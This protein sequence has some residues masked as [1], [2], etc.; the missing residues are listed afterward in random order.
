MPLARSRFLFGAQCRVVHHLQQLRERG[1]VGQ[2]FEL[3]A[4]GRRARVGAVLHQVAPPELHRIETGRLRGQVNQ[5]FRDRAGDGMAHGAVLA[6]RRLVLEHHRR[7]GAV[8]GKIVR[9]AHQVH[10]LIAF[11]RAGARVDRVGADAR[12]VIDID[13]GDA[14]LGIDRHAPLDAMIAGMDV[15]CEAFQPVGNELDR[16]AHDLGDDRHRY[17]I[18]ID[19]HLDAVAAA[20]VGADHAHVALGQA[21]VLGEHALHH[22]RR[23]GSVIDGKLARAAIVV[24]EDRPRLQRCARVARRVER[25]LDHLVGGSE[26]LLH[27]A[28][29]V[30][31]LKTKIVTQVR[32]DD[33]CVRCQGSLHLDRR[34]QCLVADIDLGQRVLGG[35]ARLGNYSGDRLAGPGGALQRQRQLRG[36]FHALEMRQHRD[37]GVAMLGEVL[38]GEH[39]QHARHCER[40]RGV[41]ID[42]PGV[43]VRAPDE[44]HVRHARQHDVVDELSAS[45]NQ[46]LRVGSRYR[47]ADIGIW[48]VDGARVD[49]LVHGSSL[50]V[51]LPRHRFHCIDDRVIAGAAA[52]VAGE[53]LADFFARRLAA[54]TARDRR[55]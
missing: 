26:S 2:P 27:L 20:D 8:V 39:A 5:P 32:M 55:R 53:M 44:C 15:G 34:G 10:H 41:D 25:R 1:L 17:F 6:G 24:G 4:G 7:L 46:L 29:L 45:L 9:A 51:A 30:D 21:H 50:S 13:R 52:V 18:G 38:A 37:P 33:R 19:M 14:A 49:D 22:V 12:Q 3:H 54:W 47:L 23:L 48:P 43:R 16:P 35:G 42:D 40:F 11:H 28:A 31:A 36:R